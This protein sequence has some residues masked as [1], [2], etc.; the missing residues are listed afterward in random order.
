MKKL[1]ISIG[2]TSILTLTISLGVV[3]A[4]GNGDSDSGPVNDFVAR[5][6][7]ILGIEEVK[8]KD[9]FDQ[10][11][12]EMFES[13][14][15]EAVESGKLTQEEADE[16][17]E[18]LNSNPKSGFYKGKMGKHDWRGGKLKDHKGISKKTDSSS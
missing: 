17:L 1:W 8:V 11:K 16:K 6:A 13:R 5:V 15:R 10:A 9:A 2:I 18:W 3:F 12:K 4:Q 14:L 7:E